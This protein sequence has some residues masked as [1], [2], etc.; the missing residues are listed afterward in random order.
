M[1]WWSTLFFSVAAGQ[2]WVF[3]VSFYCRWSRGKQSSQHLLFI[4]TL[5]L[6]YSI[7]SKGSYLIKYSMGMVGRGD[8]RYLASICLGIELSNA[9]VSKD[10]LSINPWVMHFDLLSA[11]HVRKFSCDRCMQPEFTLYSLGVGPKGLCLN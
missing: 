6:S 3:Q 10:T 1:P 5:L 8:N 4:I 9:E 7:L 2:L 11:L